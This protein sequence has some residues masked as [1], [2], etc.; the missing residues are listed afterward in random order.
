MTQFKE[1][2]SI[3]I[4]YNIMGIAT[5]T[6]TI[7]SSEAAPSIS[8][9]I[10]AGDVNFTGIIMNVYTQPIPKTENAIGGYWYT[11]NVSMVAT[12]N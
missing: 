6:Y 4:N 1:C 9:T 12:S 7:I 8:N 11:T 3:S 2:E 5:I 10:R